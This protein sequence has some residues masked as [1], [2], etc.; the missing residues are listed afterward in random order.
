MKKIIRTL[1][2]AF[3]T[4]EVLCDVAVGYM[5]VGLAYLLIGL[6]CYT[7]AGKLATMALGMVVNVGVIAYEE[8]DYDVREAPD[9]IREGYKEAFEYFGYDF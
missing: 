8:F 9:E 2:E 7:L 5:L 4:V 1:R 6:K 3:W